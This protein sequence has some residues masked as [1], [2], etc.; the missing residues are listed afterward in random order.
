MDRWRGR[1]ILKSQ[2]GDARASPV[3]PSLPLPLR[4]ARALQPDVGRHGHSL[5]L[6]GPLLSLPQ[7]HRRRR[8]AEDARETSRLGSMTA[9]GTVDRGAKWSPEQ[10]PPAPG[11]PQRWRRI[12]GT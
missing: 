8:R 4:Y 3:Q 5:A 9:T 11:I 7:Q 1:M 10:A 6:G 2:A 12:L